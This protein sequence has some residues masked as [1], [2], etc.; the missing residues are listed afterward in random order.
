MSTQAQGIRRFVD[1]TRPPRVP[2]TGHV[3][4]AGKGG[5][6]TSSVA[7]LLAFAGRRFGPVVLIDAQGG[8]GG[9]AHLLGLAG[10][11]PDGEPVRRT[12]LDPDLV[13]IDTLPGLTD[14]ERR[15]ALRRAGRVDPG[16]TL[17]VDAGARPATIGGA[18][19]DFGASLIAVMGP[20]GVSPAAGFALAKYAWRLRPETTVAGLANAA[21]LEQAGLVQHAFRS[22]VRRFTDR[23]VSWLGHLPAAPTLE[24]EPL[25]TALDQAEPALMEA[26]ATAAARLLRPARNG[27]PSTLHLMK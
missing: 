6:G 11:D 15:S 13:L 19:L 21:D 18:L 16:T 2:G 5:V 12:E 7:L 3:V 1:R 23:P 10:P 26:A 8:F 4:A 24:V 20:D 9:P 25:W 22:G 17:I 14:A 27:G